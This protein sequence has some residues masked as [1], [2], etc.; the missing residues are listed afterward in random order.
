MFPVLKCSS[1]R[2]KLFSGRK[3]RL[4]H[5]LQE[6]WWFHRSK[7]IECADCNCTE[8]SE[9][10]ELHL[11]RVVLRLTVTTFPKLPKLFSEDNNPSPKSARMIFNSVNL[12]SLK[13]PS[14]TAYP[15]NNNLSTALT[16]AEQGESHELPRTSRAQDR[17]GSTRSKTSRAP[18]RRGSHGRA[19]AEHQRGEEHRYSALLLLDHVR[20]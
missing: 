3:N 16:L 12:F 8:C 2:F 19:R 4:L 9:P 5:M 20:S 6:G 11:L 1:A 10:D 13:C 15:C 7:Y 18:E 14:V 17:R